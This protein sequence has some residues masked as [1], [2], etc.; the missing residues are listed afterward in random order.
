MIL[1]DRFDEIAA[2]EHLARRTYEF[3]RWSGRK[4]R[5]TVERVEFAPGGVVTFWTGDRLELAVKR[6]DWNDLHEIGEAER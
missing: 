6:E 3:T 1:K 5:V 4:Q 2:Q